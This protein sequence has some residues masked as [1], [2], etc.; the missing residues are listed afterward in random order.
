MTA[1]MLDRSVLPNDGSR[2]AES[3]VGTAATLLRVPLQ[4]K[5]LGANALL[6]ASALLSHA[7]FPGASWAIQ[8]WIVLGLSFAVTALLGWLALRPI[9]ELE[10]TADLVSA[11]DFRARAPMSPLADREIAR[12]ST[13][14]NKLLD[15]VESDRGRI[16]YLAGRAVRARD[17]ERQAVARELRE[18]LAQ[19]V[20]AA[21]L[22]IGAARR[23]NTDPAV[24][25]QLAITGNVIEQLTDEM[26]GMAETLFPGTLGDLGLRN[27]IDALVRRIS[28]RRHLNISVESCMACSALPDAVASALYRVADEALRNVIQHAE[29]QNVRVVLTSNG[30]VSLEIEDDG[31]GM[32][33]RAADPLQAGLGLFS[34]KAVLALAGGDLQISSAPGRGMRVSA[35]VPLTATSRTTWST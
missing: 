34:A 15:R 14:L 2:A 11:G 7:L 1:T 19:M 33:M 35:R 31:R 26:R 16:Q 4:L 3:R 24:E 12:L 18:S 5:L 22:Q 17:V 23:V 32:D 27:A 13:T 25:E 21:K 20:A 6:L 10:R 30:V 8:L 29:A 9:V 28:R